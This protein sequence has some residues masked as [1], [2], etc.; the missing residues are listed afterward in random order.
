MRTIWLLT[1][2]GFFIGLNFS[3]AAA[4][5]VFINEVAW[6]GTETSANDEWVELKNNTEQDIDLTGWT[7]K[8]IDG[9]PEITL[10]GTIAAN[11]YFLLERTDDEAVPGITASQIYTG[12]L[13]NAG[14]KLELSDTDNYLID[15][16]DC[17]GGWLA[18]DNE[19][20]QTME[21][22]D[23]GWQNSLNTGGTP[24]TQN[25]SGAEI[26]PAEGEEAAAGE[27]TAEEMTPPAVI[28]QPPLAEAGADIAALVNQEISFDASQS[29][30]PDNDLL[31]FLWNFGDGKTEAEEKAT[32]KYFYPG[33]YIAS[34]MV[35]DGEFYDLDI[36]T[37]NIYSQPVLISEFMP[38]EWIEIFNQSQQIANLTNWQLNSFTFPANSL[39]SPEQFL[40][41]NIKNNQEQI[42]LL[43]PNGSLATEISYGQPIE[44]GLAAA[45]DGQEYLWTKKPT[46]GLA[47][48]ISSISSNPSNQNSQ[49]IIQKTQESSETAI[50][51]KQGEEF[52]ALDIQNE[53]LPRQTASLVQAS[54][55]NQ[56][57]QKNNLILI[58]SIIVSGSLLVSW[59]L[60]R[61]KT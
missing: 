4:N 2:G 8:A 24:K 1:I 11:G 31:T 34:L 41:L 61:L 29:Y 53:P 22:I 39:I 21:K 42:R 45:F 9:S 50:K 44:K 30:D 60:I 5:D 38:G 37:I 33:Q 51:L 59:F 56:S 3:W 12:A 58:I 26:P 55:L 52:A 7:L 54:Q 18:G 17:S 6:M 14:E 49:P 32:H 19:T 47:N 36:I 43:Y 46:P 16:V 57:S 35:S 28:N 40:V 13:S 10:E 23:S 48:I 15:S 20:K 27:A 25:S